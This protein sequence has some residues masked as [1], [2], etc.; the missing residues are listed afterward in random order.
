MLSKKME[1][2]LNDQVK[3]EMYSAYLYLS[4]A[5]Y[6]QSVNLKGFAHWMQVQMQ[7]EMF[8][9]EK[10]RGYINDRG[11]RVILQALEKPAADF[12][13]VVQAFEETL[14]HEKFITGKIN[15]LVK[16]S[17]QENDHATNAM[18]QWFVNEQVEEEATADEILQQLKLIGDNGHGI[19]M[20][21]RELGQRVYTPPAA[22]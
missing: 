15:N 2:A 14:K 10:F 1:K 16:L 12:G 19:I 18:L 22:E 13:S 9:A 11:G 17:M 7:E 3:N 21:D 5:M 20:I 6:F 4:M 8:H